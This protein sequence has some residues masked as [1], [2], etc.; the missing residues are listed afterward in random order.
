MNIYIYIV[1]LSE[2]KSS[3]YEICSVIVITQDLFFLYIDDVKVERQ[4]TADG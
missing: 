1:F 2:N 4:R 3:S